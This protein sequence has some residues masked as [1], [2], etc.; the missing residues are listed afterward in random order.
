MS[1]EPISPAKPRDTEL[2][3]DEPFDILADA[4]NQIVESYAKELGRKPSCFELVKTFERVLSP[5]FAN[6][7]LEGETSEL[8]SV[9]CKTRS[10]PRRQK[11]QVGDVVR[12]KA[13]NGQYVYGRI[14]AIGK[15]GPMLGVYDSLGL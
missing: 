8:V 10:I 13:A 14:F 7:V 2:I 9:S 6:V 1:W 4:I 15:C 3:G 5:R 12:S 11:F